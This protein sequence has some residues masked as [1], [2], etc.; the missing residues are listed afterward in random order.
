MELRTVYFDKPG[1]GNTDTVLSIA[2]QRAE[3]LGIKTI[4]VAST[5]G[6]TAVKAVDFFK[7]L[8]VIV[9]THVTG[10][11]GP[12]TQEF[13]DENRKIV[14]SKGGVILTTTHAFSGLSAA[15]RNKYNTYVL[16]MI[17][18]DTLRIFGQGMKVACEIALMA[19]DSGLV[20]TD[21]DVISIAG[22]GRGADTAIVLKPVNTHNFFDLKVR[23]ILC[24]PHL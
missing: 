12:D 5:A 7:G 13:T 16:G 8:K 19:A 18:A 3:E 9:V 21:E 1:V 22:T 6:D 24:K 11:R 14:E 20:N 4:L 23:E 17:I 2:R 15:M 10:M